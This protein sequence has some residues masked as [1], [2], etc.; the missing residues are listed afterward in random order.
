MAFEGQGM[1]AFD[2]QREGNGMLSSVHGKWHARIEAEPNNADDQVTQYGKDTV[3][4]VHEPTG[5]KQK[6]HNGIEIEQQRV[7]PISKA[8]CKKKVQFK[9]VQ[10]QEP[11]IVNPELSMIRTK[12][13]IGLLRHRMALGGFLNLVERLDYEQWSAIMDI[14]F[15]GIL[16]VRTRLLPKRLAKWLLEKYDLWDTSLN[17]PNDKQLPG[18]Y[19]RGRIIER[20]D[21]QNVKY[22]AELDLQQYL[23]E[24]AE[25]HDQQG[26][27]VEPSTTDAANE[28][29]CPYCP[30]CKE[31]FQSIV[32][33]QDEQI[34]LL[35]RLSIILNEAKT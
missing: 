12:S 21:Y 18:E 6:K 16:A 25:V 3:L 10:V 31:K 2:G 24:L 5:K 7:K 35:F 15:E 34:E 19:G 1:G 11:I 8:T 32:P 9:N 23:K 13:W 33:V 4:K 20:L 14:G 22:L 30:H 28:W 26:I 29:Q 27:S 17:L